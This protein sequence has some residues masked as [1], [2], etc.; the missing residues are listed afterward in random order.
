M[1]DSMIIIPA[2]MTS[3]RFPGKPLVDILGKSLVQRTWHQCFR[4]FGSD[5]TY[6]ATD[7]ERIE[8]HCEENNMKCIMTSSDCLTG[9]DRVAEAYGL[10]KEKC[11]TVVNVQG[12]EPLVE[13]AD[14][15]K[16]YEAHKKSP[17]T[18]C[19]GVCRIK[20]EE[21]FKN[22][23][24]IKIVTD[25]DRNLL[26]AS[27]A[28]IPTNKKLGF[29]WAYKQV[30]IYAFSPA[31]LLDFSSRSKTPLEEVEDIEFLRFLEMGY[32]VKM[33]DVSGSSVSVDVPEDVKKV[34][35]VLGEI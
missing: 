18:V 3:S 13:P 10:L 24:I 11:S 28:G 8:K 29:V 4:A 32:T 17:T 23:N 9:T 21:E 33:V 25:K 1:I 27:R 6:I 16:V 2:R 26:Y 19:C 12:D 35:S 34:E 22:P 30:C 7:D 5:K 20:T 31:A 14:V 15:L